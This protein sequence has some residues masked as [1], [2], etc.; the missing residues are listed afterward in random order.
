VSDL[1]GDPPREPA[2]PPIE[3]RHYDPIQPKSGLRELLRKLMAPFIAVGILLAKFKFLIFALFKLKFAATALSMFVSVGAY[4]LFFGWWFAVGAVLL[5]FVHEM[6]HVIELRRQGVPASAPLFIPFLGASIGMRGLPDD[7]WREARVGLAG[8]VV[9]S[10]GAAACWLVGVQL[11]SDLLRALAYWGFLINL[12]NLIPF[13]PLDGGRAVAALHPAVWGI[14]LLALIGFVVIAPNPIL[15]LILLLGGFEV[16]RRW[17]QRHEPQ[18]AGYYKV[19]AAQRL[20]IAV[21]YF[22][23]AATLALAMYELRNIPH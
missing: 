1:W 19:T 9:G 2:P 23:L 15:L 21:T 8:P 16:W 18:Y 6:G 22:G 4:A 20:A 12:F 13:L 17:K 14:G 11:D 5:I 7:A 10:L 3:L